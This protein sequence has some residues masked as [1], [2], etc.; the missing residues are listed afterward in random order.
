MIEKNTD[1]EYTFD[2]GKI[3]V[4]RLNNTH[5]GLVENYNI[6]I[7]KP[8]D[9]SVLHFIEYFNTICL[10]DIYGRDT[11][12]GVLAYIDGTEE[13]MMDAMHGRAV[14]RFHANGLCSIADGPA[15]E[16]PVRFATM[17]ITK[18]KNDIHVI[19][20]VPKSQ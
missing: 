10:K 1:E 17:Q 6:D 14:C 18:A 9:M 11:Y 15:L 5:L 7:L 3:R 2:N 19:V 4:S 13:T 20:F 12:E 16:L 8:A